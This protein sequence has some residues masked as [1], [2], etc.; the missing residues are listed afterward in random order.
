MWR[1]AVTLALWAAVVPAPTVDGAARD[2]DGVLFM[3]DSIAYDLA[4][5][6]ETGMFVSGISTQTF[7]FPGVSLTGHDWLP[8]NE[9]WLWDRIPVALLLSR[10]DVVVWQLS[11]WD[12]DASPVSYNENLLAHVAFAEMA[13]RG[14]RAVVF[15]TPPP[16]DPLIVE[17]EG[18]PK[19]WNGLTSVA[20]EVAAR[21]PG[22]VFV[23]DSSRVWGEQYVQYADDGTPLRKLDGVH[24]CP[25]GATLFAI[26]L[27]D[28][29]AEHFDGVTVPDASTWPLAFWSDERYHRTPNDCAQRHDVS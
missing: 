16:I 25:L 13:L 21:Y 17:P 5:A 10:A 27:T 20:L 8:E 19:D 4:P 9:T 24:V 15:V 12:A 29:M 1:L 26:F 23:L 11:F 22:R 18:G 6:V 28:W 7:V 2:L 14:R 3:G